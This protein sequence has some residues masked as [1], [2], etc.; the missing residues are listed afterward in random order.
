M[1]VILSGDDIPPSSVAKTSDYVKEVTA[2]SYED[3]INANEQQTKSS[4]MAV[5]KESDEAGMQS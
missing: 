3:S 1:E 5:T 4:L 2:R